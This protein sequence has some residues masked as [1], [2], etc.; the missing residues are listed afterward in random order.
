MS[1]RILVSGRAF[2]GIATSLVWS[3]SALAA[4]FGIENYQIA[5]A[6]PTA[7]A[8]PV[9]AGGDR[10][11]PPRL[12]PRDFCKEDVARHIGQRAYQKAIL[13]LKPAQMTLWAAFETAADDVDA[14]AMARC[15]ALPSELKEAPTLVQ[16]MAFDGDMMK[17]RLAAIQAL[18]APLATLYDALT[19]E[20][21]TVLDL[22]LGI[23]G[24]G[25]PPGPPPW[26]R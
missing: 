10:Q 7:F 16:R 4:D 19:P 13:E 18:N 15:S 20:Q 11:P 17:E 2:A 12:A 24:R 3:A 23:P 21:K 25:R 6:P 22:P 26:S 8:A 1:Y 9:Q 5:Q 14:K